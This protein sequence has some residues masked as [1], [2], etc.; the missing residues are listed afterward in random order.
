MSETLTHPQLQTR[1]WQAIAGIIDHTLLKPEAAR[2]QIIRLC[3][4]AVYFG[5]ATVCVNPWGVP[6]AASALSG[7]R[8]KDATTIGFPLGGNYT[9]GKRFGTAEPARPGAP[10]LG[11]VRD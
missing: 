10:E 7:S 9:P 1:E 4:E 5:F 11:M 6:L 3:E 2:D 8:V